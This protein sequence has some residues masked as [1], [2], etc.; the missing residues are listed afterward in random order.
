MPPFFSRSSASIL[1][2]LT[3]QVFAMPAWVIDS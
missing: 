3:L 1:R 2:T